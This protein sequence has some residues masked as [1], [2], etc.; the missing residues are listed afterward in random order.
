MLHVQHYFLVYHDSVHHFLRKQI[1]N[2]HKNIKHTN[3]QVMNDQG[4]KEKENVLFIYLFY[5]SV[6]QLL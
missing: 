1:Y 5:F 3:I 2:L 4:R 6:I